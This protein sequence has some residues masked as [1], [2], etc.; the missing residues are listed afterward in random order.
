MKKISIVF[1]VL[2]L[3][4]TGI[5]MMNC[6]SDP[7]PPIENPDMVLEGGKYQVNFDTPKIEDGKEYQV[8]FYIEDCDSSLYNSYLGGKICYKMDLDSD[9]EKVLSGW[10]RPIPDKVNKNNF[11]NTYIWTFKAGEKNEDDLTIDTGTTPSGGKQYFAFTAQNSSWNDYP[12]GKDFNVKGRFDIKR[13]NGWDSAGTLTLGNVDNV[14]GKSELSSDSNDMTKIRN[15]PAGSKLTLTVN[16]TVADSGGTQP[17]YGIGKV[18]KGWSG[19]IEIKVP[20]NASVGDLTFT[21]DIGVSS[22]L[23]TVS[24]GN[25][26][27]NIW[28][29]TITKAELFKPKN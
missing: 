16:V 21:V 29:C 25:L 26:V 13:I 27:I 17:G 2:L 23:E 22:I 15:M 18:G 4:G 5:A 6:P 19:N 3:V 9:D 11:I 8:I 14:P 7:T 20:K 1:L 12:A 28:D 24:G 10:L